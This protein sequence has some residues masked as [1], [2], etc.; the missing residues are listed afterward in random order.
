MKNSNRYLIT[1]GS[2][3]NKGAEAMALTVRDKLI[4]AFPDAKIFMR[5]HPHYNEIAQKNGVIPVNGKNPVSFY[6]KIKSKTTALSHYLLDDTLIDIGG[7]QLG[8]PWGWKQARGIAKKIHYCN[9]LGTKTVFM[10]QA[11]GPFTHSRF[12]QYVPMIMNRC[13]LFYIRD[14]QSFS[15]VCRIHPV[16]IG[17]LQPDVAW[18]FNANDIEID[19]LIQKFHVDINRP[20]A[21]ITPNLRVYERQGDL[22]IA[23]LLNIIDILLAKDYQVMLLGHELRLDE[24]NDDRFLCRLL[25]E[26]KPSVI[27]IDEFLSAKQVKKIISLCDFIVSSRFHALI[28]AFSQMIP[29]LA[30]GW[31]HKYIELLSDVGL[32][33]NIV[34]SAN[35]YNDAEIKEILSNMSNHLED[36]RS[37]LHKNVPGV[38]SKS[39]Q[40]LN[41][42][43]GIIKG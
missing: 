42:V 18:S 25:K 21:C 10:P 35:G 8:D 2:F 31:S 40:M 28:A 33:D 38:I 43:I 32:Q 26:K 1:G 11:L 5:V 17:M 4:S 23:T 15:A 6:D 34:D 37:I 24:R 30:I 22:Y 7:Y 3:V 12:V 9:L 27:H 29:A 13:S 16:S 41:Q 39:D 19:D 20:I 36:Q 14:K